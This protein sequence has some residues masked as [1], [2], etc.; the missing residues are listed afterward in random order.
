MMIRASLESDEAA[1]VV[2]G[3]WLASSEPMIPTDGTASASD[4]DADADAIGV[5]KKSARVYFSD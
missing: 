5:L 4:A 2:A 3:E 1:M